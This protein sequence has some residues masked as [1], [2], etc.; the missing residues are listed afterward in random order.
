MT[1]SLGACMFHGGEPKHL[2]SATTGQELMDLKKAL[3]SGAITEEEYLKLKEKYKNSCSNIQH[4][5]VQT[6]C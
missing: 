5:Q 6:E 4:T 1:G 3:D 2:T